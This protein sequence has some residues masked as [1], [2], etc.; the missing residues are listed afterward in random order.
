MSADQYDT[1]KPVMDPSCPNCGQAWPGTEGCQHNPL[2]PYTT[3]MIESNTWGS[4]LRCVACN[5]YALVGNKTGE[6]HPPQRAAVQANAS[7]Q[8]KQ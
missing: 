8:E 7:D 1:K 6:I 5:E 4:R 3:L 2:R